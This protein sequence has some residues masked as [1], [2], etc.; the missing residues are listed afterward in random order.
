MRARMKT[1]YV[2]LDQTAGHDDGAIE[3]PLEST[4]TTDPSIPP[5]HINV[6]EGNLTIVQ[7]P[8]NRSTSPFYRGRP[9]NRIAPEINVDETNEDI[10]RHKDF[11]GYEENEGEPEESPTNP[12]NVN[13]AAAAD[14]DDDAEYDDA[15]DGAN[16]GAE[17][18]ANDITNVVNNDDEVI[19][20]RATETALREQHA[21]NQQELDNQRQQ[22]SDLK[23]QID[24]SKQATALQTAKKCS[25]A[26]NN[27]KTH[28][29]SNI[30][31][32]KMAQ[33]QQQQQQQEQQ[34]QIQQLQQQVAQLNI[35]ATQNSKTRPAPAAPATTTTRLQK[36]TKNSPNYMPPPRSTH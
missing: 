2:I 24:Q 25:A 21:Q 5:P 33:K 8:H 12:S 4:K 11:A 9:G 31:T 18:D 16:G 14:T 29:N 20:L 30:Q 36:F 28:T 17:D 7:P 19:Q 15:D 34:Q 1:K 22:L 10:A 13:P 32:I 3:N 26:I 27:A 35:P 6:T 23:Q